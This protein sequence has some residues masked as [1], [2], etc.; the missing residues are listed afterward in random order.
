MDPEKWFAVRTAITDREN[1]LD[2]QDGECPWIAF[3]QEID[4]KTEQQRRQ[5][6]LAAAPQLLWC[7]GVLESFA[8]RTREWT[9][10]SRRELRQAATFLNR[11]KAKLARL[12]QQQCRSQGITMFS[13]PQS[14]RTN[15][16]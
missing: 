10:S 7:A 14:G 15:E 3:I 8:R 11:L 16:P 2:Y 1:T 9:P 13:K 12:G 5:I 4:D 6:L